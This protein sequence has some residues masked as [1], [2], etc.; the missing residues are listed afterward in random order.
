MRKLDEQVSGNTV[1]TRVG[2]EGCK[3]MLLLFESPKYDTK[4]LS[5]LG[6]FATTKSFK[7]SAISILETYSSFL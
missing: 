1:R 6:I 3:N 4:F 2:L 7:D 5:D